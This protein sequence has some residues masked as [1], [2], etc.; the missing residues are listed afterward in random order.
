MKKI[1]LLFREI[2]EKQIKSNLKESNG[3]FIVKYSG[4]T[5][6]D[7]SSLRQSLRSANASLFVVKNTTARRALKDSG[8]ELLIKAVEGPCGLVFAKDE[9]VNTSRVLYDF[10]KGHENLKL[11]GGFLEERVLGKDDIKELAGLPTKDVLRAQAVMTLKSP[12]SGFVMTLSQMVS[13]FVYCLDQIK[14][15]KTG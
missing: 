7:L 11:E 9:P 8:L 6:P 12:V 4:L 13:R 1:G 10:S 5:S 14:Q 15:K 3:V 2:S